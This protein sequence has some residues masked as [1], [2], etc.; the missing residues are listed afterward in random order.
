MEILFL[1]VWFGCYYI[2][3]IL[4]K[5]GNNSVILFIYSINVLLISFFNISKDIGFS[6]ILF[7]LRLDN[8]S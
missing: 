4:Y 2:V 3:N 6:N 8:S 5:I 1:L 7:T